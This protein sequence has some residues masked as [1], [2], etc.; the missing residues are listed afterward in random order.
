MTKLLLVFQITREHNPKI[1]TPALLGFTILTLNAMMEYM[2]G[3]GKSTENVFLLHLSVF[4]NRLS[5]RT[6][7]AYNALKI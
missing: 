1:S 5:I 6:S 4:Y 2:G 7:M 3:S